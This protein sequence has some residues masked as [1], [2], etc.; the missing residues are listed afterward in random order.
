MDKLEECIS[1]LEKEIYK[2]VKSK[3]DELRM[4]S[5]ETAGI[6]IEKISE[7][8]LLSI[9][10]ASILTLQGVDFGSKV[11]FASNLLED[12]NK[13]SYFKISFSNPINYE[14]TEMVITLS[15][16]GEE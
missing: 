11:Y 16:K 13:Y 12:D 6:V 9:E 10:E 8:A 1:K 7:K 3:E 5:K 14:I 4:L 15:K 2:N